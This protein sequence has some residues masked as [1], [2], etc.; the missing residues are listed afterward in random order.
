MQQ[1]D[2][3]VQLCQTVTMF[4][5]WFIFRRHYMQ[6]CH[7]EQLHLCSNKSLKERT[8]FVDHHR[9]FRDKTAYYTQVSIKLGALIHWIQLSDLFVVVFTTLSFFR[10]RL[11]SICFVISS[12][13]CH[14]IGLP[15]FRVFTGCEISLKCG[16]NLMIWSQQQTVCICL[17]MH[18]FCCDRNGFV[19]K[20]HWTGAW[21]S[22]TRVKEPVRYE[23]PLKSY[24]II[25]Q[26]LNCLEY[27]W[28]GFAVFHHQLFFYWRRLGPSI[29]WNPGWPFTSMINWN[30]IGFWRKNLLS[31]II[32]FA[33]NPDTKP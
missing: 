25:L 3:C 1:F 31:K 4:I 20:H 14:V 33:L 28:L 5:F 13:W 12:Y 21:F 9:L 23:M 26:W 32:Y 2:K 11:I 24:H 8:S 27:Q 6:F 30:N 16:E 15:I 10:V 22:T 18:C 7:I 17:R 19:V 29:C